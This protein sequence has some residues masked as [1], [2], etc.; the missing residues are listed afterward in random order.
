MSYSK[1][2]AAWLDSD[3]R[4]QDALADKIGKSQAAVNRYAKGWRFPDAQ[5]AR[6]IHDAT[7]GGVP[8]ETWQQEASARF[9]GEAA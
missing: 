6:L 2:L 9:L 7:E 1:A 8:F 3:G 5:T 4:T